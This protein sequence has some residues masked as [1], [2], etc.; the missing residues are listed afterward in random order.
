V[1]DQDPGLLI[2]QSLSLQPPGNRVRSYLDVVVADGAAWDEIRSSLLLF[3]GEK[4]RDPLPWVGD[5]GSVFF[6]IGMELGLA[7]EW[8]TELA[9]LYRASQALRLAN[10]F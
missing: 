9:V 7:A 4:Q 5:A 3:L 10:P 8:Q 2:A 6:R 1:P